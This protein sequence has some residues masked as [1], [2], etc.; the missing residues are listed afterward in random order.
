VRP[1]ESRDSRH[2]SLSRSGCI[3]SAGAAAATATLAQLGT[4]WAPALIAPLLLLLLLL[5]PTL[6]LSAREG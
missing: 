2:R 5:A 6:V 3:G 4:A 1:G